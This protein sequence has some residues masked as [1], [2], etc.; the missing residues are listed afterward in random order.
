MPWLMFKTCAE[1]FPGIVVPKGSTADLTSN[2]ASSDT[3]YTFSR[4]YSN[5]YVTVD[6]IDWC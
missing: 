1:V 3:S 2:A 4:K 6:Y 5:E